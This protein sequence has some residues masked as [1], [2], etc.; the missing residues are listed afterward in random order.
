M[1]M[2]LGITSAGKNHQ[3]QMAPTAETCLSSSSQL[4]HPNATSGGMYCTRLWG[5]VCQPCY[6]PGTVAEYV[7]END[8][9]RPVCPWSIFNTSG[10]YK[11]E[12]MQPKCASDEPKDLC[13]LYT[14][15]CSTKLTSEPLPITEDGF[16]VVSAKQDTEAMVAFLKRAASEAY[17]AE[18]ENTKKLAKMAYWQWGLAPIKGK[19][20]KSV[21]ALVKHYFV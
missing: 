12:S 17:G 21:M 5:G 3:L 14:G 18:I 20:M 2:M 16:A 1:A 15:T 6:V 10:D 8:E 11:S 19:S 7:D 4:C 13:C 9:E